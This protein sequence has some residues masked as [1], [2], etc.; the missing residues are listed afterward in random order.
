MFSCYAYAGTLWGWRINASVEVGELH[1]IEQVL[2]L[3]F[4][5]HLL[6]ADD[7]ED[8]LAARVGFA[9]E[10][11]SLLVADDGIERRHDADGRLH[12]VREHLAVDGDAVDALLAQRLRPREQNVLRLHDVEPDQRLVSVQLK[13][14]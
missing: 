1:G 2:N 4:R 8:A 12:V 14:P 5:E 9:R 13:L 3:R 7:L 11:R 6:L 10:L